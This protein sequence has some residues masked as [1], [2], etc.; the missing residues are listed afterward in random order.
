VADH[1]REVL[2]LP[3]NDAAA[4]AAA[5]AGALAVSAVTAA[6]P[7]IALYDLL[8]RMSP[9]PVV[10]LN[11]AVAVAMVDGPRTALDLLASLEADERMAGH[12]RLA[13]V[14][15]HCLELAGDHA[16]AA[17]EYA[18]AARTATSL[19]EPRYLEARAAQLAGAARDAGAARGA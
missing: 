2:H 1:R 5:G 18:A 14:C 3:V 7:V 8:E 15:A 17:A 4:P 13:A 10:T 19:P 12:H 16:A 11:R 9:S 6:A